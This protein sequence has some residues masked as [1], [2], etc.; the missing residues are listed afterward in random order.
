MVWNNP[1]TSSTVKPCVE[2]STHML[3]SSFV[4]ADA[5]LSQMPTSE[6]ASSVTLQAS[7]RSIEGELSHESCHTGVLK[8]MTSVFH[9]RHI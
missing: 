1:V 3:Y 7:L 6:T 4:F 5:G 2:M 9:G 8:N